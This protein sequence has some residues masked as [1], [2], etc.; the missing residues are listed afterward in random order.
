MIISASRRTDIPAFY[1][2]W[3][4]ERIKQGYVC[5]KNPMNANQIKTVSLK[6]GD[7]DC[8]VFWTKNAAPL[9]SKMKTLDDMRYMYYFLWTIT[10]YGKDIEPN[11]A[12]K[13]EIIS[14]F[15]RLSEMISAKRVILRYDPII[16]NSKYTADFHIEYFKNLT[17]ELSGHTNKCIISFVDIYNKMSKQAKE[18]IGGQV[19][20]SA[21][22][23]IA[24]KL[25]KIAQENNIKI[26]TCCEEINLSTAGIPLGACIDKTLIEHLCGRELN[27]NNAKS[28]RELCNCAESVDIG[29][30]NCCSHGCVYCYANSSEKTVNEN[31]KKHDINSPFLIGI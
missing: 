10:P 15:I 19:D 7:V 21:M 28:Q 29:A 8:I 13:N 18:I 30:Y 23:N 25:N 16:I 6:P 9:I 12:D 27:I 17:A 26:Q 20:N 31:I 22:I 5:V 24:S 2:D 14:N 3:F 1:S 11:I 4:I